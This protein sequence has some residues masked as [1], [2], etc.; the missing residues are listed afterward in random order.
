MLSL[1][2]EK[3]GEREKLRSS[4]ANP[5]ENQRLALH[6][7]VLLFLVTQGCDTATLPGA[8][9]ASWAQLPG[10]EHGEG[11]FVRHRGKRDRTQ[12]PSSFSADFRKSIAQLLLGKQPYWSLT[13]MIKC[14]GFIRGADSQAFRAMS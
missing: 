12:S 7:L 2:N 10:L 1:R 14:F 3:C 8:P 6:S 11:Y 9:V 5:A 13:V 4:P